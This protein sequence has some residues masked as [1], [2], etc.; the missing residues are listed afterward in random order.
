MKLNRK[1][2]TEEDKKF[3]SSADRVA[4]TV[5]AWPEWKKMGVLSDG[6]PSGKQGAPRETTSGPT[7]GEGRST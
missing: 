2:V 3:W 1:V 4:E 7:S 5:R 6:A